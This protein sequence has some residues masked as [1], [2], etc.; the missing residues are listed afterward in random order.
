[1]SAEKLTQRAFLAAAIA[2]N[3]LLHIVDVSDTSQ[4][5][6]GSSYKMT[7]Q[8]LAGFMR[9]AGMGNWKTTA[10]TVNDDSTQGYVN[11]AFWFDE[12]AQKFYILNDNSAGAADWRPF[13]LQLAYDGGNVVNGA[14]VTIDGTNGNFGAGIDALD[15]NAAQ[16]VA[17]IGFEAAKNNTG[18]NV[19]ASGAGAARDNTGNHVNASGNGAA[20]E[21]TGDNVNAF[22]N[23]AGRENTASD[24]NFFGNEAGY[25]PVGEFGN[26]TAF[27]VTVF[28][29]QSIPSY[30]NQAAADAALTVANGCVAGQIYLWRV[31]GVTNLISFVIPA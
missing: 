3:D 18:N 30:A 9:L 8:Q 1:M 12:N 31:T 29:P 27:G 28:S 24:S 20:F 11:G 7:A 4:S 15:G 19:T 25:D 6:Q 17:G 23:Q 16:A 22:G 14:T 13:D 26:T 5:P 2:L 10:P 21:N